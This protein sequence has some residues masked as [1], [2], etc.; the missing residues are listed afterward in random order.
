MWSWVLF[1]TSAKKTTALESGPVHR[2]AISL[3]QFIS[4]IGSTKATQ[5]LARTEGGSLLQEKVETCPRAS[6]KGKAVRAYLG[7]SE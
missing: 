6:A 1:G 7:V 5:L 4:V 2:F 3:G